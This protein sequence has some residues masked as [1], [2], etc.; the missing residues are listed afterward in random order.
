[1]RRGQRLDARS[2]RHPRKITPNTR[3]IVIINPN[4]PTGALYPDELLKEIVAIAREHGLII[5][6]DEIYDKVLYDGVTHTSIARCPG[7]A[8]RDLQRPVQELPLLRLPRRLDG[9]VGR[10]APAPTTSKG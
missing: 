1:V 5:F 9:G 6:A 3:G 8:D 4:N 10:Q 2:R 7:R